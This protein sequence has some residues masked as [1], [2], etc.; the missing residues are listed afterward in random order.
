VGIFW[1]DGVAGSV[2]FLFMNMGLI[3]RFMATKSVDEGRKAATFNILFML[4]LSAIVVGNAGWLGKAISIAHPEVIPPNTS[5]DQI[6]V[7]VSNIVAIPGVFGF[8]MAALT[9]ALMSTVDTLINA[10]AAI[11]INDIHRP[12]RDYLKK[13][14]KSQ[15]END[16]KELAAARYSSAI[17]TALGVIAVLAFK[18]FP[19]VYEAHGYFHST[20]TPPLVVA[21]FLG[22]FWKRFTPAAVM[23]TFIGG[24]AL[25]LLGASH[26]ATLISP[27]DH[28]IHMNAHHPYSYI[29][30]LYNLVV[31]SVV[32]VG[33]TLAN[34]KLEQL[35]KS[36]IKSKTVA[37]A[38][39]ALSTLLFVLIVGDFL[40]LSILIV[41]AIVLIF[42]VAMTSFY[43]IDYDPEGQTSG[44]TVW[45]VQKAKEVFKG[46]KI[47][48]AEGEK[49]TVAWKKKDGE[50][51]VINFSKNDMKK[52]AAEVGDF[53]YI[54]DKRKWLGGL[55]S[56]HSV[57]GEPHT[58]D[59]VVYLSNEDLLNGVF[60]EDKVLE[61]EKEM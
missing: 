47:N 41:L 25:M 27:F 4:P 17:I 42:L 28:G 15:K 32:G 51:G 43:L 11:Y 2:G 61:A 8:I 55:K 56:I 54:S 12:V 13:K 14:Y 44:L 24:V 37:Y 10:T 30:A 18:G 58:E 59:G 6:F 33:V 7:V 60:E 20:L 46:R 40:P 29:R 22:I 57:Y 45:S 19:T 21:I 39:I 9:A 23:T 34:S 48:E 26:P 5:P 31:C 3:M 16:K 49:V 38:L 36:T 1:Q 52:M 53:V 35:V 50:D